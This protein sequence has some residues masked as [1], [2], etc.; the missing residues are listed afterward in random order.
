[1]RQELSELLTRFGKDGRR[2]TQIKSLQSEQEFSEEELIV[3]EDAYVLVTADGGSSVRKRSRTSHHAPARSDAVLACEI[4]STRAS[5]VFFSNFGTAYTSRIIDVPATT[6]YGEPIQKLF[7]LKD[8][9]RII[10]ALSL[11]PRVIGDVAE[12]DGKRPKVYGVAATSDGYALSFGL[13]PF[14]EPS[15][16][17]GRRYASRP[18]AS[19]SSAPARPRAKRSPSAAT[20]Q[21]R[22][23]L[24]P[25]DDIKLLVRPRQG[26]RLDQA[27]RR[28]PGRRLHRSQGRPRHAR[29]RRLD[30]RRTAREYGQ[31]QAD[32]SRRQRSRSHETRQ[33]AA[34][35][36]HP[37]RSAPPLEP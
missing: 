9:E 11:D 33:S 36:S 29:A 26:R 1:V 19:R 8:G 13:S 25:V 24:A 18:K 14:V 3:A 22:A 30:G 17:A 34:R 21:R 15:T 23:L 16:R 12:R 32:R 28:R 2:R 4:G 7:K 31:I 37:T 6:G 35:H 27:R 20:K 10:A 5:M